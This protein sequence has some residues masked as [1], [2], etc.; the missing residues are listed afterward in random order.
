MVDWQTIA[1]IVTPLALIATIVIFIVELERNRKERAFG[2]FLR[3]LDYYGNLLAERRRNW[4]I[5]K[6]KV[7]TN[8]KISQEIGD[9]T[10][11]LDYLLTRVQQAEPFYA[12]EHGLLEDEIRSLNILNELCKIAL[13]HE[14]MSLILKVCYSSDI[15]F[16][17]NRLKDILS[18]LDK[19]RQLRL[20]S[21]PRYSYL[22]KLQIVDYF[23]DLNES[24]SS[25]H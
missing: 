3:L 5:I 15:S 25:D 11:S 9:K 17:Q 24:L 23:Q 18:I 6:E 20:F 8:P 2:T 14:Q 19:E 7:R 16:Y 10:S 4:G 12:I 1:Y 21:I 13:K 22:Q